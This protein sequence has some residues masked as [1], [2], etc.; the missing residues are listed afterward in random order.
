MLP[1]TTPTSN[2]SRRGGGREENSRNGNRNCGTLPVVEQQQKKKSGR[3]VPHIVVVKLSDP[4]SNNDDCDQSQLL[5]PPPPSTLI[6]KSRLPEGRGAAVTCVKF[7]PS[8]RYLLAGYGV[9]LEDELGPSVGAY[10]IRANSSRTAV[11]HPVAMIYDCGYAINNAGGR[12]GKGGKGAKGGKGS[13]AATNAT[14]AKA[15]GKTNRLKNGEM[16]VVST[17]WGGDDDVNLAMFHPIHGGGIVLGMKQGKVR[18]VDAV[19]NLGS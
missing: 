2:N 5:P 18:V 4:P 7:S 11:Q 3:Y 19:F 12:G 17:V 8:M 16:A 6:L 14:K 15:E 1:A 13:G 10:D 9:R